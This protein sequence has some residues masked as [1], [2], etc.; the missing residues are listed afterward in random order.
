[1][2]TLSAHKLGGP[3]GCGALIVRDGL[4]VAPLIKGG[5]QEPRRRAERKT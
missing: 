2:M 5:G 1:M 3:I 4:V